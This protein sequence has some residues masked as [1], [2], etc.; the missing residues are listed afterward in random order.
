MYADPDADGVTPVFR[1]VPLSCG[2]YY[3]PCLDSRALLVGGTHKFLSQHYLA[4]S[5]S[6]AQGGPPRIP[7]GKLCPRA[8]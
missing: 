7:V 2:Q 5:G 8:R 3:R 6:A 4:S 1:T